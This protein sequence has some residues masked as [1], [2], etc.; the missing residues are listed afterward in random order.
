MN[1]YNM[2]NIDIID[3]I[4][5]TLSPFKNYFVHKVSFTILSQKPLRKRTP[6][7][8]CYPLYAEHVSLYLWVT[9]LG[10]W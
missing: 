5:G 1:V 7:S 10:S 6:M 9:T 8:T 2:C 4:I 3:I